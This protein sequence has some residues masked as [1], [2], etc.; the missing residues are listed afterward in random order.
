[1]IERTY[2]KFIRS[3]MLEKLA[4]LEDKADRIT[5]ATAKP[6]SSFLMIFRLDVQ[7]RPDDYP[8]GI[9]GDIPRSSPPLESNKV[10]IPPLA[11]D[12]SKLNRAKPTQRL[13]LRL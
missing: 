3:A 12:A 8:V 1:M 10:M 7:T 6:R 11:V 5:N 2:F 13:D 4:G 9:H